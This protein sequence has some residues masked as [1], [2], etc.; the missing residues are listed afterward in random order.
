MNILVTGAHGQLGQEIQHAVRLQGSR[1]AYYFCDRDELDI[2][3]AQALQSFLSTHSI[4]L[5]INAA[6]YTAVD[7]AEQEPDLAEAINHRAVADM[8]RLAKERGAFLIHIS[9]DYVFS[10]DACTPYME[11]APTSPLGV[12]GKTKRL[13]EEAIEASRVDYLILRTA[14]LYS[15]FAANFVKTMHRLLSESTELGVVFDQVG[16]PTW[17]GDLA[18]FLYHLVEGGRPQQRGLYHF[19]NEGVCSWY[20]LAEAIRQHLGS[21]CHLRPIRSAEYPTPAQRPAYS[22]LD[23]ARL[24]ADFALQLPH[25]QASLKRCLAQF[26]PSK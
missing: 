12:Y 5:L 8:A 10:G 6:A 20:D 15:S 25:W 11:D 21:S 1:H 16:T 14:W 18:D 19:T 26:P 24:K 9:T 3:D 22:V 13:G 23:K 7:R 17:A 4:D 2:T